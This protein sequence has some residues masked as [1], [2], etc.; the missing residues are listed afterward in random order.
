MSNATTAVR[1]R[2]GAY[3]FFYLRCHFAAHTASYLMNNISLLGLSDGSMYQCTNKTPGTPR[4]VR[5]PWVSE[6][7]R[8][9]YIRVGTS[10]PCTWTAVNLLSSPLAHALISPASTLSKVENP[11]D[12]NV[13]KVTRFQKMLTQVSKS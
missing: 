12:A 6:T 4:S 2:S 5:A 13:I 11:A 10:D 3:F 1:L 7:P 9:I 8:T